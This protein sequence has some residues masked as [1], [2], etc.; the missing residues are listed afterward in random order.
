VYDRR[1]EGGNIYI[2]IP[3]SQGIACCKGQKKKEPTHIDII[4]SLLF[5]LQRLNAL[6]EVRG[7]LVIVPNDPNALSEPNRTDRHVS[8]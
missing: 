6:H 4:I 7:V 5:L 8:E 3:G 1:G 2:Y